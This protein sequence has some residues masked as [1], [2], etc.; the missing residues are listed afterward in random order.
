[1]MKERMKKL[2]TVIILRW[3]SVCLSLGSIGYGLYL[4][5][6]PFTVNESA[7]YAI[8]TNILS[9]NFLAGLL[10]IFGLLKLIFVFTGH[11]KG[12]LI[13]LSGLIFLWTL[14]TIGFFVQFLNGV[15]NSGWILGLIIVTQAWGI[16]QRGNFRE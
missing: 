9:S 11:Q 4:Q 12:L 14:V 1:M 8:V 3:F 7:S 13:A 10:V 16:S 6:Y 15:I 5:S 2:K